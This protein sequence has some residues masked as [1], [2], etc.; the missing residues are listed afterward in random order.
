MVKRP[1]RL[2]ELPGTVGVDSE[3]ASRSESMI[4][5]G[6]QSTSDWDSSDVTLHNGAGV[7]FSF[8]AAPLAAGFKVTVRRMAPKV[9]D[10]PRSAFG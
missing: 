10:M 9:L 2:K 3:F 1:G 4:L 6:L 7:V 5:N 8:L